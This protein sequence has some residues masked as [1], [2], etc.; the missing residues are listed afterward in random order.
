MEKIMLAVPYIIAVLIG[1]CFG[2]INPAYIFA[3]FKGVNILEEGSH[4]PGASNATLT[5]GWKIGFLVGILDILKGFAAVMIS[6]A[7]FPEAVAVGAAAGVACVLG[8]IFPITHKLRGGKGFAAFLGMVLALDWRLFLAIGV[9]I[10]VITLITDYIALS[11]LAAVIAEPVLLAC[12]KAQYVAMAIVCVASLVIILRH[13][14]NFKRI[15]K[16][17]EKGVKESLFKK[18]A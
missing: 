14:E 1:Y 11:T 18:K 8:H 12:V 4:N 10:I 13:T 6:K 3:K 7:I 9:G 17:E 5:M 2:C 16:G 15:L